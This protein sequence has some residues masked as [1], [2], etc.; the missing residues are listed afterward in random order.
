MYLQKMTEKMNQMPGGVRHHHHHQVVC[1]SPSRQVEVIQEEEAKPCG[2][3]D[4]NYTS[5]AKG[6]K[7]VTKA[8]ARAKEVISLAG[9]RMTKDERKRHRWGQ[10]EWWT[11]N[12][13]TSSD[14]DTP[15]YI[16]GE[17]SSGGH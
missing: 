13:P 17:R 9:S 10:G 3:A 1:V 12:T 7:K 11:G 15:G 2:E 8:S 14:E 5:K 6:G 4:P 16:R